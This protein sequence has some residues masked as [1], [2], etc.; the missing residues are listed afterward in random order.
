MSDALRVFAPLF[1]AFLMLTM[2]PTVTG[3][4]D[5]FSSVRADLALVNARIWTNDAMAPEA[6]ALAVSDGLIVAI[7]DDETIRA[8]IDSGTMVIDAHGARVLPGLIDAHAHLASAG[9]SLGWI[10]L[11]DA[12]SKESLLEMVR[13]TSGDLD[14][15]AW[16]FGRGWS[17]EGWDDPE[18]PTADE[19]DSAAGGRPT[20]LVRMDGHQLLASRRA[21]E[22]A[23]IDETTQPPAGGKFGRL[24]NG[25]PSGE[26]YEE[27][28]DLIWRAAPS[29][30]DDDPEAMMRFL[31][32]AVRECVRNGI[33]QVGAI[34]SPEEIEALGRLDDEG[35]LPIRVGATVFIREDTIDE[36]RPVLEW[37]V[38]HRNLS[39]RVKVLGFKGFMDGSLGS[40]TAWMMR[41]YEDNPA[42]ENPDN[43]GFPLAMAADG[44][45]R[46]LIGLGVSMGLQP[47]IHAI[48][49]RANHE[50][51]NWFS[52]IPES[53]RRSLRP[54]VEHAQH[55]LDEDVERFAALGVIPNMQPL[56][57]ADDGRYAGQR[58]GA[59]RLR[60]SYAYRSFVDQG[61]G[62]AFGSDWPVVSVN[63]F[64]GIHGA[65]SALTMDGS[66][67]LPEQ[68]ITVEESLRAYCTGA[69]RALH[70]ETYTGALR[71]GW[72]ADFIVLDRDVLRIS[73]DEVKETRVT[74]TVVGGKVVYRIN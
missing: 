49:T 44:S 59:D 63:P 36:W 26:V 66:T 72:A 50:L 41:P 61:A 42:D 73:I 1:V 38:R 19:I 31:E 65:V 46:E 16:V 37:A 12:A 25:K 33:T 47:T 18:P 39:E 5:Q 68:A 15:E 57:K 3:Q 67:F 35:R 74:T 27:A 21:L 6:T 54:R 55:V 62:L 22:L 23:G 40:R 45:L 2:N 43:A 10:A 53:S 9:R 60:S 17:A 29:M 58:M 14:E 7:G 56:H 30:E 4:P 71:V 70:S 11:R 13:E 8:M 20:I 52:E 51:L 64:L 34:A 24:P 32:L 48:G 28:M 69:S